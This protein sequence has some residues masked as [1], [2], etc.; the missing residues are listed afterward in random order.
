[1][2][3]SKTINHNGSISLSITLLRMTA[4]ISMLSLAFLQMSLFSYRW[5][6]M[7]S[8]ES[9]VRK[10]M[11]RSAQKRM[12]KTV[13]KEKNPL[14][15]R[16]MP[17]MLPWNVAHKTWRPAPV[18]PVDTAYVYNPSVLELSDGSHIFSGRMSWLYGGGCHMFQHLKNP[19]PMYNCLRTHMERFTDQTVL[20]HYKPSSGELLVTSPSSGPG[21]NVLEFNPQDS[22]VA[23]WNGGPGWFDTRLVYPYSHRYPVDRERSE[24]QDAPKIFI[25]SQNT[26]L[27]GYDDWH[28]LEGTS[29]LGLQLTY[30]STLDPAALINGPKG[31]S[32]LL[33]GK[34][35]TRWLFY[36]AQT[37]R[38]EFE[39]RS[40][41]LGWTP[42]TAD[43]ARLK[44]KQRPNDLPQLPFN[45]E[46]SSMHRRPHA[47][48]NHRRLAALQGDDWFMIKDKNWAPFVYK[49]KV[50]WSYNI[51]PHIVCENDI[52]I[53][54]ADAEDVDCVLCVAKYNS[55][56]TD[57]FDTFYGNIKNQGYDHVVSHLNGAPSYYVEEKNVYLGLLH[58]I[59]TVYEQDA[60]GRPVKK[61]IYEHHF[62]VTEAEPPFRILAVAPERVP[63]QRTRCWSP[64]FKT[65]DV[66]DS[67]FAMYMQ[68]HPDRPGQEIVISYGDGDR[69]ARVDTFSMS[70]V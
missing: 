12:L 49:E 47:D 62:Y 34:K 60:I 52:D 55:S 6:H 66:V 11:L 27:L 44:C 35:M 25:T 16:H 57:V 9:P 67:E 32:A 36:D 1:M 29:T 3:I 23:S 33:K 8:S 61:R 26:E 42:I 69:Y 15:V 7:I 46:E 43:I 58:V 24:Q 48:D 64:W 18:V 17:S 37:E 20:G 51:E 53:S 28:E 63:L 65:D 41:G 38:E 4:G 45:P 59:K 19:L 54:H 70:Q 68:Y 30:I 22:D 14:A 50:L 21:Q 39:R 56:S 13:E 31:S 5:D 2:K 10:P 40:K